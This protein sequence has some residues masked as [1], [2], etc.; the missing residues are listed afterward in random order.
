MTR[1]QGGYLINAKVIDAN[2]N[3]LIT[4]GQILVPYYV[5]DAVMKEKKESKIAKP[6][7]KTSLKLK[8]YK[9]KN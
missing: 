3:A 1:H 9:T 8:A 6:A 4:S 5:V 2:T 7:K